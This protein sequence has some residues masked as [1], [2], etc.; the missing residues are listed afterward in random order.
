VLD[1][2]RLDERG[3]EVHFDEVE[4]EVLKIFS[5]NFEDDEEEGKTLSLILETYLEMQDDREE[6]IVLINMIHAEKLLKNLK[7]LILKKPMKCQFLI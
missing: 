1:E 5:L 4:D 3:D 2:T 7:R 6:R